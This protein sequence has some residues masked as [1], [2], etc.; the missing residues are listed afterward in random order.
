VKLGLDDRRGQP[1]AVAV[2]GRG[3]AVVMWRSSKRRATVRAIDSKGRPMRA[4]DLGHT[5][6]ADVY[7]IALADKGRWVAGMKTQRITKGSSLPYVTATAIRGSVRSRTAQSATLETYEDA[8]FGEQPIRVRMDSTGRPIAAW[9][10]AEIISGPYSGTRHLVRVAGGGSDGRLG[11]PQTVRIEDEGVRLVDL[12]TGPDG[13]AVV[14]W[15]TTGVKIG[16]STYENVP[17]K[18]HALYRA[19]SGQAFGPGEEIDTLTDGAAV[20]FDP[21]SDRPLAIWDTLRESFRD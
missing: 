15:A 20:A 9:S 17:R 5:E 18:L 12:E 14:L 10:S 4:V 2:N 16:G 3:E 7:S 1:I 11:E 19:G 13:R 21:V 6:G 8:S